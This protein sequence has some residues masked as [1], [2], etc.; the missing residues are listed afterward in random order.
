MSTDTNVAIGWDEERIE[1]PNEGG[2]FVDL[3]PGNYRFTVVKFERGRYEGGTK[4]C[5]CPMAIITLDVDAAEL[6]TVKHIHKLYL[7][8]KC[9]GLLCAF[10]AGVGLRKHG[11]P[12][13]LAWNQL[14][15]RQGVCKMG[16]RKHEEKTY[17]DIKGFIDPPESGAEQ[18]PVPPTQAAL[19]E[20]EDDVIPF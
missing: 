1:Q 13:V 8:K 10:F 20:T 5:A 7:N 9:E 19:P 18:Q 4:M 11:D 3:P 15:G 17:N 2:D 16:Q 12:L 14:V 6:G